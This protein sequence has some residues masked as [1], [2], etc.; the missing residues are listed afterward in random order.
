[1][2]TSTQNKAL[3]RSG[4]P[5]NCTIGLALGSGAA[6]G[7]AHIGVLK[8]LE[9]EGISI[10]C[11]A[12]TSIGAFIGALYAAGVPVHKMEEVAVGIDWRQLARWIDPVI[13]TSGL[14][15]GQRVLAF[16]AELLPVKSFEQLQLPLAVTATDVENGEPLVIR[17]GNLLD[18]LRAAIA[19]PG[20]FPP[21][22]FGQRFLIDGGLCHPVPIDAVRALGAE[23]IIAV[24]AIPQ[25]D[26]SVREEFL[27]DRRKSEHPD[28][29]RHFPFT[30]QHIE[31]RFRELWQKTIAPPPTEPGNRRQRRTPPN[32]FKVCAQ[33]VAIMEN[34]INDLRLE[35]NQFDLLIRP[36]CGDITLL[37]FHRAREA[38]RA[39]ELATMAV[40]SELRRLN[41]S[42]CTVQKPC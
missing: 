16:M 36:D 22:P 17:R 8:V 38:I 23:K 4:R 11:I 3:N 35:H 39:G 24:C 5:Q 31:R 10:D 18:A 15:D 9:R 25:V 26:K 28:A 21:A 41:K 14:I 1:M 7:L 12:G 20:I 6:R 33:S 40:L 19:F 2:T 34:Q 30:V 37:E 32:L 27:P 29:E 13:P 42:D